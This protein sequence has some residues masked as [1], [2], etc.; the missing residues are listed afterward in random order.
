MIFLYSTW[1]LVPD[2]EI[3]SQFQLQE[4]IAQNLIKNL[5]VNFITCLRHEGNV[6]LPLLGEEALTISLVASLHFLHTHA[7]ATT[8]CLWGH[9]SSLASTRSMIS[10]NN[11]GSIV[12]HDSPPS[13]VEDG[14][15]DEEEDSD[16]FAVVDSVAND[17]VL[18]D[19]LNDLE[20]LRERHEAFLD[21]DEDNIVSKNKFIYFCRIFFWEE[22]FRERWGI[23]F[24]EG[25]VKKEHK[26]GIKTMMV[27]RI[28]ERWAKGEKR[29]R[30][31][32]SLKRGSRLKRVQ[33]G[34]R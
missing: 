31:C 19:D 29:I 34:D 4:K 16:W 25:Y 23:L 24:E 32:E 30:S 13:S 11:S 33:E 28:T 1:K 3:I 6:I 8:F 21:D 17:A 14:D 15:A 7:H 20:N 22:R 18:A 10:P 27:V 26:N 12:D 5:K 9:R 2:Y